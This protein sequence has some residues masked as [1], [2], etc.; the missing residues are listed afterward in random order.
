MDI[1]KIQDITPQMELGGK[2]MGLS[3]LTSAKANVPEFF[4][5]SPEAF[6]SHLPKEEWNAFIESPDIEHSKRLCS[7]IMSHPWSDSLTKAVQGILSDFSDKTLFAVRSSMIGED[8]AEFSFAGQLESF[9]FQEGEAAVVRSIRECWCSA[10]QDR[11]LQYRARAGLDVQNISMA[12]VV[13]RMVFSETAGVLFT[14]HP[15]TGHRSR[16]LVSAAYGQGEGVVSGACNA[17]EIVWHKKEG[18]LSYTIADKDRM[19]V[20]AAEMGVIEVDVPHEKR[21]LECV[22]KDI[23]TKLCVQSHRL[24]K[25]FGYP[26]DIEWA[27]EGEEVYFL[28]ARPITSL[29]EAPNEEGPKVVWDNSNIQESYCGVT[30]PLTFSYAQ[31]AYETVY[32][33]TM[34]AVG[35]S[36]LEIEKSTHWRKNLLGL[37]RGRIFYNINSWYEGLTLLPSFGRNKEDMEKMMGLEDPVDF[38]HDQTFTMWE[39]LQKIPSTVKNLA[40][41]YLAFRN[42]PKSVPEFQDHYETIAEDVTADSVEGMSF[43]ALMELN[44]YLRLEIQE[45]WHIPIINDFYVMMSTGAL[46]RYLEKNGVEDALSV[47]NHL[48]AGEPGIESTEPTRILLGLTGTIRSNPK[49]KEILFSDNDVLERMG[50]EDED[51]GAVFAHYLHRYGDRVAGE[52]KLETKTLHHDD[53]F[54]VQVLRTYV[55]NNRLSLSRLEEQ[56]Q[57][58]RNDA[59]KNVL[60]TIGSRKFRKAQKLMK[61][62]R[63]AVKNRENM[64]LTRT[65]AFGLSRMIY[66]ALGARLVEA[67]RLDDVEDIFYLT[68]DELEEYHEGRSVCTNLRGL[69]AVRKEEF[70]EYEEQEIPHHFETTGAVYFGN[71]FRYTGAQVVDPNA[72]VLYGL[73]CYPGRVQAPISLIHHPDEA[74][75]L[76]GTILCTVRTD[77]G[78][79]PLFPSVSGILVER[80]STL[81]HSAVVARE[82]GIP[83]VVNVAGITKILKDGEMVIM[84]GDQGTVERIEGKEKSDES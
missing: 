67:N 15:Q 39:K 83:A 4:V 22:S 84:D 30:T 3:R 10:F 48:L 59:E 62:M 65:R 13:Q 17:D 73:G 69:A 45:K 24:E 74:G 80:G 68:V 33:Q 26:I 37:V 9:L 23:L 40:R 35:I 76:T 25:E 21:D 75:D 82:L 72:D 53:S 34:E 50:Q 11:V 56:E 81:S 49:L 44:E 27:Q 46:R 61:R 5:V 77:P 36:S 63:D 8:G 12:V 42:L 54:L 64:R 57:K 51:I 28:Q 1:I 20:R 32:R 52:L 47:Q 38:V 78:W 43:S 60:Q 16:M 71:R 55:N 7:A 58:L 18:V 14:A 79:A 2:A 19:I 29:P 31:R 66:R 6:L 41:L 70:A